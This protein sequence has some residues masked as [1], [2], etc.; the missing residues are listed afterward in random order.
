MLSWNE[1]SGQQDV[2]PFIVSSAD[3]TENSLSVTDVIILV[4]QF[5]WYKYSIYLK[6]LY[7]YFEITPQKIH[8][9]TS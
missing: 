9:H 2:F 4:V 6:F 5:Y 8:I 3:N 7:N 1:A